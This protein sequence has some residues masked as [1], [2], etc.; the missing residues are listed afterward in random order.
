MQS[1]WAQSIANCTPVYGNGVYDTYITNVTIGTINNSHST[2]TGSPD[3]TYFNNMVL[4]ATKGQVFT[5]N[6]TTVAFGSAGR[7][8]AFVDFN[9][10]GNFEA[11]ET[12]SLGNADQTSSVQITIP[13]TV[14][15]GFVRLRISVN[16][17]RVPTA[18]DNDTYGEAED[19]QISICD[20][21]NMSFLSAIGSNTS[22]ALVRQGLTNQQILAFNYKTQGCANPYKIS[23]IDF[24]T[25]LSDD[26]GDIASAKLYYSL[27]NNFATATQ[28]GSTVTNPGTNFTITGIQ[29]GTAKLAQNNNY[30]WLTYDI[31][32]DATNGNRVDAEV[33]TINT[34]EGG[35][36][37]NIVSNSNPTGT[38]EIIYQQCI[39]TVAA[40]AT[41]DDF[42]LNSYAISSF[43]SRAAADGF[44]SVSARGYNNYSLTDSLTLCAGARYAFTSNITN[45]NTATAPFIHF[46]ADWNQ[47]GDF[48]DEA[49]HQLM[50]VGGKATGTL[51]VIASTVTVTSEIFVPEFAKN[52]LTVARVGASGFAKNQTCGNFP[53]GEFDDILIRVNS[54]ETTTNLL[55]YNETGDSILLATSTL[56]PAFMWQESTNLVAYT[57]VAGSAN[58]S[59]I[60]VKPISS[61]VSAY[62]IYQ[63][64]ASC[65]NDISTNKKMYSAKN[66]VIKIGLDSVAAAPLQVCLGDSS[67]LKSYYPFKSSVFNNA[68]NAALTGQARVYTGTVAVTSAKPVSSYNL[69]KVCIN[70]TTSL[71]QDLSFELQS[72]TGKKVLLSDGSSVNAANK[73]YNFCFKQD[74]SL[75]N[76]K[77]E[78]AAL[79]GNYLPENSWSSLS[80]LAATGNWT[81]NIYSSN[82]NVTA[83][84]NSWNL[85]FG[86]NDSVNWTNPIDFANANLDSSKTQ[87]NST[88]FFTANLKNEFSAGGLFQDSI[89]VVARDPGNTSIT[90]IISND[91]DSLICPGLDKHFMAVLSNPVIGDNYLWYVND[92]L[93]PGENKDS[94]IINSLSDGNEL[95][96][97]FS[98]NDACG[99]VFSADSIIVIDRPLT[100]PTLSLTP[101]VVFPLCDPTDFTLQADFA[102]TLVDAVYS[103]KLNGTEVAKKVTSYNFIG[104][105]DGDSIVVTVEQ[106]I[107]NALYSAADTL[108]YKINARKDI[109]GELQGDTAFYCEGSVQI[110]FDTT[111]NNAAGTFYW[112]LDGDTISNA[113]QVVL[114]SLTFGVYNLVVD[115]VPTGCFNQTKLTKN[116]SFETLQS[117]PALVEIASPVANLC[118]LQGVVL[119]VSKL[120]FEGD[121]P[122]YQWYQNGVLLRFQND[123]S[124]VINN[125]NISKNYYVEMTTDYLCPVV[126]TVKSNTLTI[127]VKKDESIELHLQSSSP[128]AGCETGTITMNG[129]IIGTAPDSYFWTAN[130]TIIPNTNTL[131]LTIPRDSG[132]FVYRLFGVKNFACSGLDTLGSIELKN[133]TNYTVPDSNFTVDNSTGFFIASTVE[134]TNETYARWFLNGKLF[135]TDLVTPVEFK[136][137]NNTL[138]VE[139]SNGNVCFAQSCQEFSFV[140]V[141]DNPSQTIRIYPN[142][143]STTIHIDVEVS[144][145]VEYNI[146][147]N[148]G[149]TI[150]RGQ[151]NSQGVDVSNLAK[152]SYLLQVKTETTY[153]TQRFEKL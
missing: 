100:T 147:D 115:Y 39:P 123:D 40:A 42:E 81:L 8:S 65:A 63:D 150:L 47:D 96:V 69:S 32:T 97:E 88:Q 133:F 64:V 106:T 93:I 107:C 44:N 15:N 2:T 45:N 83:T 111:G 70:I 23:N 86:F 73:A 14:N 28:V 139:V 62:R 95:K 1:S 87:I 141:A 92:V 60:M 98:L 119:K 122:T 30:F 110:A 17:N 90:D 129:S 104:L 59:S 116:L 22:T 134:N 152:G 131:N 12:F 94:I 103:W 10:N 21:T 24:S 144:K 146:V 80:G 74:S 89:Q 137:A 20:G 9:A 4:D 113:D 77:D 19:Y 13:A 58:A 124:L 76:I 51:V 49:E 33:L 67:Y 50:G 130:D 108:V 38:R 153:A 48:N 101:S 53:I 6:V 148:M 37:S 66:E 140:G 82:A 61:S 84:L 25:G 121:K 125:Q 99:F 18:C 68:A 46:W 71:I 138:C 126:P 145:D 41:G 7:V 34:T 36:G 5:L 91:G 31:A 120:D 75:T 27:T 151:V 128:K 78:T 102:D 117:K 143:A 127:G 11:N 109:I 136:E 114:D 112:I 57:D 105:T 79:A 55:E 3:Y 149:K 29:T 54:L 56:A 142:P 43:T 52:G 132:S 118:P 35:T 85:K 16:E 135:S 26:N 72:P